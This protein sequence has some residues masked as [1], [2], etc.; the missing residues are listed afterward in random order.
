MP[1]NDCLSLS[2]GWTFYPKFF[3][4]SAGGSTM[5]P[6]SYPLMTSAHSSKFSEPRQPIFP[7]WRMV[8]RFLPVPSSGKSSIQWTQDFGRGQK[9]LWADCEQNPL[10]CSPHRALQSQ[11]LGI[12]CSVSGG[13]CAA[14]RQPGADCWKPPNGSSHHSSSNGGWLE[15]SIDK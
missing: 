3:L 10:G 1:R 2:W 9:R 11:P 4:S 6:E 15:T 12:N 5:Q 8:C 13:P 7:F 14:C